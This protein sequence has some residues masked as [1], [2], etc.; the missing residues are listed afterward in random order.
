MLFRSANSSFILERRRRS[1]RLCAVFL[2]I[3]L[4]A[5]V[6]L[7][8]RFFL[9]PAGVVGMASGPEAASEGAFNRR[10]LLAA[11]EELVSSWRRGLICMILCDRAGG[12]GRA[13]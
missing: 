4:P 2:A 13:N 1:M 7:D 11:L 5:A 8:G 12:G 9:F 3:F 6:V 10:A